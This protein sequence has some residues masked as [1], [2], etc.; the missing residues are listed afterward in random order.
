MFNPK[1]IYQYPLSTA[2]GSL[3]SLAIL[4]GVFIFKPET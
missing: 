4:A 3:A 1:N 2:L